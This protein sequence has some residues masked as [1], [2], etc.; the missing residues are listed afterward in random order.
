L[1]AQSQRFTPGRGWRSLAVG[2]ALVAATPAVAQPTGDYE[3]ELIVF[4]RS[5]EARNTAEDI[6]L[7][8]ATWPGEAAV[9][10]A[11]DPMAMQFAAPEIAGADAN[12]ALIG[13]AE[14][15]ETVELAL[16]PVWR[17]LERLPTYEPLLHVA[18]LAEATPRNQAPA[19]PV[20][21]GTTPAPELLGQVRL[22]RQRSLF[23]DLELDLRDRLPPTAEPPAGIDSAGQSLTGGRAEVNAPLGQI[24]L[25][26]GLG[27]FR[28]RE[29]RKMRPGEIH[30]FDHPAFGAIATLRSRDPEAD[31]EDSQIDPGVPP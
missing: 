30:Y 25:S 17:R 24:T 9:L 13:E 7:P 23:L 2:L 20:A 11:G 6:A 29:T 16:G 27:V 15:A 28:L 1:S 31:P 26:G 19:H 10:A 8:E 12:P 5:P 3:V 18:W 4:R 22:F 21:A 14:P